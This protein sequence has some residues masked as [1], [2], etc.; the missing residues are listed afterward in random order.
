MKLFKK[1]LRFFLWTLA[2]GFFLGAT[3]VLGIILLHTHV[4]PL[5]KGP[6][7]HIP[8]VH[9]TAA[10]PRQPAASGPDVLLKMD[11]VHFRI[12]EKLAMDVK[13]LKARLSPLGGTD[14]VNFDNINGFAIKIHSGLVRIK[15][16]VLMSLFN[17]IVLDYDGAPLRNIKIV[18]VQYASEAGVKPILKLEGEMKL[19]V[20]LNFEMLADI[21]VNTVDNTLVL[22]AL[23]IK[24]LKNP[25]TRGLM[26]SVG[27]GLDSVLSIASGRGTV[28]R[29]NQIIISPFDIFPPPAMNGRMGRAQVDMDTNSLILTFEPAGSEKLVMK[30]PPAGMSNYVMVQKGKVSF[31]KLMMRQSDV[32]MQD[33]NRKDSFDFFLARYWKALNRGEVY[34]RPDS[35]VIVKMPDYEVIS[36]LKRIK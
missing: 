31:G 35:S 16:A 13:E 20:W 8:I 5:I 19:A 26:G 1:L 23:A 4:L 32:I 9:K 3:V 34:I 27:M 28:I 10:P 29:G 15:P 17:D 18:F 21:K 36:G 2:I 12:N 22:S 6:P 24:T 25:Y 7:E 30:G 33:R 11:N 14:I